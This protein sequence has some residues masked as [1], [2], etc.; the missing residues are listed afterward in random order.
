MTRILHYDSAIAAC[1]EGESEPR[2]IHS[3]YCSTAILFHF[4]TIP[5]CVGKSGFALVSASIRHAAP[6]GWF[7]PDSHASTVFRETPIYCAKSAC[8]SPALFLIS[9]ISDAEKSRIG[10][11]DSFVVLAFRCPFSYSA[12]C[13]RPSLI[14]SNTDTSILP[15]AFFQLLFKNID[16]LFQLIPLRFCQIILFAFLICGDQIDLLVNLKVNIDDANAALLP[17]CSN[18]KRILRMPPVSFITEPIL[19]SRSISCCSRI[20]FNQ[21]VFHFA[22]K[23]GS[24][25]NSLVMRILSFIDIMPYLIGYIKQ[26]FEPYSRFRLWRFCC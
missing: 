20:K 21:S 11:T 23:I 5:E 18:T 15:F 16:N 1:R 7:L 2:R 4:I 24:S 19:G 17:L 12:A 22:R 25:T 14:S 6:L 8:V 26:N 13:S 3:V 10:A 9:L